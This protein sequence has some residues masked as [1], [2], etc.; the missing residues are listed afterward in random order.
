M[1][2]VIIVS[3]LVMSF[4]LNAQTIQ[5]KVVRVVNG[6]ATT[7]LDSTNVQNK[8]RFLGIE[9]GGTLDVHDKA[10][11]D[12]LGLKEP[13][14]VTLANEK[15]TYYECDSK[16]PRDGYDEY[17]VDVSTN[18][19]VLGV[20]ASIKCR[21]E[22]DSMSKASKV[23]EELKKEFGDRIAPLGE[24]CLWVSNGDNYVDVNIQKAKFK[25]IVE[26]NNNPKSCSSQK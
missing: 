21:D 17:F 9:V 3:S 11:R 19:V 22:E 25:D 16:C 26:R 7:I 8:V 14:I 10:V 2:M 5:G 24:Y 18:N 4:A 1:K 12:S 13:S 15:F 20:V 23:C 6:D